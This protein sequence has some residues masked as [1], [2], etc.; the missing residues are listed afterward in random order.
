M[1]HL[2]IR[3]LPLTQAFYV[4]TCEVLRVTILLFQRYEWLFQRDC[5]LLRQE[6]KRLYDELGQAR[7]PQYLFKAL[8]SSFICMLDILD[9]RA[10][11]QGP[12][13]DH[14]EY[15]LDLQ[16]SL[17]RLV[18]LKRWIE[19]YPEKQGYSYFPTPMQ[20]SLLDEAQRNACRI[21]EKLENP[22]CMT[23]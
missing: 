13:A 3:D 4:V 14:H 23:Q 22:F 11:M 2:E 6:A 1:G 21:A 15:V 12:W 5:R 16:T 20:Q 8:E 10:S 7:A 18:P 17:E 19:K 9:T